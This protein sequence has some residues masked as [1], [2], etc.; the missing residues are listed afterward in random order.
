MRNDAQAEI[1]VASRLIYAGKILNL[2]V[3]RVRLS[4]GREATREV[5][6]HAPAV[7]V[8]ALSREQ[9]VLLVKQ[10]RYPVQRELLE[11]PAGRLEAGEEPLTAAQRE[12]A[13]ETGRRARRWQ[14]LF[15]IYSS[16]GFTNEQ[17]HLFLAQDLEPAAGGQNLDED[18][19]I[20]VV[21]VPLAQIPEMIRRGEIG[22]AKSVAGLL[23]VRLYV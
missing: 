2:R 23:G 13:E 15:G 17:L 19:L 20:R 11:I 9:N 18:E 16:P 10:Y 5:A 1:R 4:N 12:L 21:E 7:A 22:D 6:E 8:V 3:D 14:P